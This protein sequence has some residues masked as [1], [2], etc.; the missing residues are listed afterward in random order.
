MNTMN[1]YLEI[2]YVQGGRRKYTMRPGS[3]LCF[4]QSAEDSANGVIRDPLSY[5][6]ENVRMNKTKLPIK[7]SVDTR[8]PTIQDLS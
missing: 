4:L 3:P 8:S 5:I 1:R 6:P 7:V 2:S